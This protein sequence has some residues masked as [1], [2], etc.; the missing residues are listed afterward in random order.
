MTN[1]SDIETTPV[2][3]PDGQILYRA[4]RNDTWGLYLMEADGGNPRLL[5]ETPSEPDWEPDAPAISSNQVLIEPTPPP[6]PKPRVQV[7]PGMGMLLVS[8]LKNPDEMT[9]TINNIEHKVG[10]FRYNTIPLP[11]GHYTWTASWPAKVSR[12][13]IADV[14]LGQVA[15]PV[16][17]R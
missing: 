8:N 7:P 14:A 11:P 13:G 10:P 6:P 1:S 5:L 2:W 16:V 3:T 15:Y 12:T 4:R 17:E 9:F